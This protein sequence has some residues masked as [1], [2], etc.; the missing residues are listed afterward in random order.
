MEPRS[1]SRDLLQGS[2]KEIHFAT[3][4]NMDFFH[5]NKGTP[6][7]TS[8]NAQVYNASGSPLFNPEAPIGFGLWKTRLRSIRHCGNR[9]LG[10]S[11]P[12]CLKALNQS[13]VFG[14]NS[15][16][17]PFVGFKG[18]LSPWDVSFQEAEANGRKCL[19]QLFLF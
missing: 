4:W 12:G 9:W 5:Q 1:K 14:K 8:C 6:P 10:V 19:Q 2:L 15:C 17:F 18:D 7:F 16:Y 3:I 11:K 13:G